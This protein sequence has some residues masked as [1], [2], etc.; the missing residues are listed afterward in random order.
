M[1]VPHGPLAMHRRAHEA[2]QKGNIKILKAI[3]K[4]NVRK[5]LACTAATLIAVSQSLP[6][7]AVPAGITTPEKGE[8]VSLQTASQTVWYSTS[9]WSERQ[10]DL[11]D[12]LANGKSVTPGVWTKALVGRTLRDSDTPGG[13]DQKT[14]GG[15][16]GIDFGNEGVFTA[17]DAMIFGVSAGYIRS[18][19]DFSESDDTSRYKGWVGGL[20]ATYIRGN[21]FVDTTLKINRLKME[22]NA[23]GGVGYR[24]EPDVDT[25]GGQI[26]IG[27]RYNLT[28]KVFIE[29]LATVAYARTSIDSFTVFGTTASFEDAESLKGSVGARIGKVLNK[30]EGALVTASLTGRVWN[31]FKGDNTASFS[32]GLTTTTDDFGGAYGD[33]GGGLEVTGMNGVSAF[34]STGMKFKSDYKDASAKIGLRWNF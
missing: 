11:R 21:F 7:L 8:L 34:L 2:W 12:A 6:A 15:V 10:A 29:P 4:K 13:Y 16:A 3:S 14:Y 1:A 27:R 22:Y 25:I 24:V 30:S 32:S 23:T 5:H 26:D 33:I 18:D 19:V 20:Y 9:P 28:D 31:E 17:D